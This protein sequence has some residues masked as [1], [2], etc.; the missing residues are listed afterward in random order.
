MPRFGFV[1]SVIPAAALIAGFAPNAA[2]E[3]A[4]GG[5]VLRREAWLTESRF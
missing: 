2:G 4:A 3:M 1:S 5:E